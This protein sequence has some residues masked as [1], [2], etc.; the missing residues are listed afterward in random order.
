MA[1]ISEH[2]A[3]TDSPGYAHGYRSGTR[4]ASTPSAPFVISLGFV[5][6][7]IRVLNITTLTEAEHYVSPLLDIPGKNTK[8]F[9][10]LAAGS[11]S[12]V[13][14]GIRVNGRTFTVDGSA[15]S[16]ETADCDLF[17]EAWA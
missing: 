4:L 8:S 16:L 13:D 1:L 12:Y 9:R 17:W 14:C 10:C 5:P 11:R 7:R 2:H 6:S 15:V 3:K